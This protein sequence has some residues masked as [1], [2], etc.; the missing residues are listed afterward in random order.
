MKAKILKDVRALLRVYQ[1]AHDTESISKRIY[2]AVARP[3]LAEFTT[4]V[5]KQHKIYKKILPDVFDEKIE[6]IVKEMLNG[7]TD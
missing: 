3:L 4:K 6:N 2:D 7:D 5:I 1:Y